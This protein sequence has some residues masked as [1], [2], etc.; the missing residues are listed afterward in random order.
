MARP[1]LTSLGPMMLEAGFSRATVE[2]MRVTGMA[3]GRRDSWGWGTED[4]VARWANSKEQNPAQK[5]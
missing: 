4:A 5:E 3:S 1:V 2:D